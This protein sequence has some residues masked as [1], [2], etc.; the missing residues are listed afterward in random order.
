MAPTGSSTTLQDTMSESTPK[1]K[2]DR[3]GLSRFLY[4]LKH[5]RRRF[6]QVGGALLVIVLAFLGRPTPEMFWIGTVFATLGMLVRLWASGFVMKNEVLATSGPYGYV[7]HPLYVGNILICIGFCF[8]CGLWWSW[9]V[10]ALFL[11]LFYPE[12]I[13][14][15]DEK[16]HRYFGEDW[17]RWSSR[18]RA[19]IPRLRP[20]SEKQEGASWSLRRSVMRNG[21]PLHIVVLGGL[22]IFLYTI[23]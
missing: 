23:L 11:L 5:R 2:K 13:R 22:L 9:I 7:R 20:Y 17:E 1:R 8:A 21:E 18:T 3:V 6:R 10:S 12:T 15:E 16:L 14:Y 19:L 4:D